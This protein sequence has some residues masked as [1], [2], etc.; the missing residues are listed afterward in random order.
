[1]HLPNSIQNSSISGVQPFVVT[2]YSQS[3]NGDETI[4]F[5]KLAAVIYWEILR[6]KLDRTSGMPILIRTFFLALIR[7]P[8]SLHFRRLVEQ[9]NTAQMKITAQRSPIA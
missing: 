6:S 7:C 4:R 8:F 2:L 3:N 1:M 5:L 9:K